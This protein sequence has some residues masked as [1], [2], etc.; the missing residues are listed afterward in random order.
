[1][2]AEYDADT[3]KLLALIGTLSVVIVV[4]FA[5]QIGII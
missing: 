3:K 4:G 1:M 5:L 2:N